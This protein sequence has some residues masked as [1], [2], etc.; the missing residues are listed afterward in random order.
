MENP[1]SSI[2]EEK[3]RIKCHVWEEKEFKIEPFCYRTKPSG[4]DHES[5]R[6]K[7]QSRFF[8]VYPRPSSIKFIVLKVCSYVSLFFQEFVFIKLSL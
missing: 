4:A 1:S 8:K 5:L 7:G 6:P 3:H 2:C